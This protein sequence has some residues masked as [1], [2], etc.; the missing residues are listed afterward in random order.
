MFE[1][2]IL[3]FV[4]TPSLG[5]GVS[6]IAFTDPEELAKAVL[7]WAADVVERNP[8]PG[9]ICQIAVRR[10]SRKEWNTLSEV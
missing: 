6:S 9:E 10:M 4:G 1:P 5:D 2:D 7:T 8:E 3:V